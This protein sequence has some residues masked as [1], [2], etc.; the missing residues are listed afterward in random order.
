MFNDTKDSDLTIIIDQPPITGN[1]FLKHLDVQA[2]NYLCKFCG[3]QL[4]ITHNKVLSFAG[5]MIDR[6]SVNCPKCHIRIH[7]DLWKGD[8]LMFAIYQA[9]TLLARTTG[10]GK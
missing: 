8:E 1:D 3:H 4:H 5:I 9:I 2:N 7:K 10:G 6:V